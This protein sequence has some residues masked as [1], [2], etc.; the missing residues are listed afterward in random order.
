[1]ENK[2]N[3]SLQKAKNYFT[4]DWGVGRKNA[5]KKMAKIRDEIQEQARIFSI[6]SITYSSVGLVGGGLTVAGIITAPFTFGVSLGLT[7]AGI[8]TGVTTGIASITHGATK[9]KKVKKL[10]EEATKTLQEHNISCEKMM[11]ILKELKKEVEKEK[12]KNN[13]VTERQNDTTRMIK[14]VTALADIIPSAIKDVSQGVAKVSTEFMSV[15]VA[16]GIVVDL[17]TLIYYADDLSNFNQ[18][19][20]CS[21]AKKIQ[22]VIKEMEREYDEIAKLFE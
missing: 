14:L 3:L 17:G 13:S 10:C 21:E 19:D 11:N 5:I 18:G 2:M 15:L 20:L 22:D 9:F 1:M 6:G 16:V 12:E 7:V 4:R 8:A